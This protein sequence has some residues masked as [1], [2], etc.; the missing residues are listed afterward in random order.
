MKA[1]KIIS[2]ITIVIVT[3]VTVAGIENANAMNN[4]SAAMLA[5]A[6]AVFGRPVLNAV[7]GTLFYPPAYYYAPPARTYYAPVRTRVIRVHDAPPCSYYYPC[8]RRIYYNYRYNY[9]YDYR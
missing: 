8:E 9:Y 4:E 3:F 1:I 6:I 5:G 7:A 2:V